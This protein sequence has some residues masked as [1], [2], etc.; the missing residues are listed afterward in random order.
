[1]RIIVNTLYRG[2]FETKETWLLHGQ[3]QFESH[4]KNEARNHTKI[5]L[6]KRLKASVFFG[7]TRLFRDWNKI[8]LVGCNTKSRHARGR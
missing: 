3:S 1:M 7:L 6:V 8:I 2:D 4:V 5:V